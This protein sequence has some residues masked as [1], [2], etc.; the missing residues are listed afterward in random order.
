MYQQLTKVKCYSGYT[1]PQEPKS[2]LWQGEEYKVF[3]IEKEWQEPGRKFFKIRTKDE[4]VFELC[5]NQ[6]ED[7]WLGTELI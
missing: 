3:S 7:Q 2:F 4:R 6:I 1:Y 5:Y